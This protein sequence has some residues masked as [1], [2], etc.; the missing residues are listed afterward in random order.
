MSIFKAYDIRGVYGKDLTEKD[1]YLIGYYLPKFIKTKKLKIGHDLRLSHE[2]LTKFL[3]KGIKDSD[4]EIIYI[5][6]CSTPNFYFS[7]FEE[8]KDGIM[9]TASHNPKEYNGFKIMADMHSFYSENGLYELEKVIKEDN[10]NKENNFKIIL[11]KIKS[12]SLTE[13]LKIENIQTTQYITSYTNFLEK[14]FNNILNEQDIKILNN[15]KF[16]IDFSSGMSSFAIKELLNKKDLKCTYHNDI[17][18]GNFPIHSP[19]PLKADNFIKNNIKNSTFT[20]VFDGD[21]DR[22]LFYDENNELI[23]PDHMITSYI[24][25]LS[26]NHSAK[27]FVCDLRVSKIITDISKERELHTELIRVGRAFYQDYMEK[28]NCDFGAE[29]SGHLFFKEFKN[30]DNPDIALIYMLKI[31]IENLKQN[32]NIKFSNIFEKYKKY[33]KIKET[34]IEIENA[35]SAIEKLKLK[36]KKNIVM[37]IDGLSFDFNDYWFNIRKSNTEPILKINIEGKEKEN[38]I[39][40]LENIISIL[41]E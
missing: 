18:D 15:I 41:K 28:E 7:L 33:H 20:A 5:G 26:N 10:D 36:Y 13:F 34:V 27:K 29:L 19:D 2:N 16:D 6:K 14:I 24:D 21:G 3:L 37:E 12:T 1:A 30:L 4:C 9:I 8:T 32:P 22:I 35:D 31:L 17:P 38:T 39:K 25:F 40:Q 11:E 23:L